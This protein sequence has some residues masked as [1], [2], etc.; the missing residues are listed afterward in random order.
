MESLGE[1]SWSLMELHVESLG[2]AQLDPD[3]A[4]HGVGKCRWSLMEPH[5]ESL[6]ECTWTLV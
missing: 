2:G 6:G 1:G 3:G 4:V 5:M